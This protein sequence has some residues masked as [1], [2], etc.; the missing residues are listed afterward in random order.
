MT[1]TETDTHTIRAHVPV[2]VARKLVP[3]PGVVAPLEVG[4]PRSLSAV[5]AATNTGD[6]GDKRIL[7]VPQRDPDQG[8]P[9]PEDLY[10]VGVLAEIVQETK[11]G[12]SHRTVVLRYLERQRVESFEDSGKHL[13]ATV[14]PFASVVPSDHELAEEMIASIKH[15]MIS[16][17]SESAESPEQVKRE[18]LEIEDPDDLVDLAIAHL[19]L[20][21]DEQVQLL[22]ESAVM[23]RLGAVLPALER[24]GE[25]LQ[26]K[27]DIRDEL[28]GEMSGVHREKVLRDRMRSIKEEL[29]EQD[30]DTEIDE[31]LER[32]AECEM[33]DEIRL[34]AKKQVARMRMAG[35]SSPE[36]NVA[37]T[38]LE[39]LLDLPWGVTTEDTI[40]VPAAR[41]ILDHDHAGLDK[42]KKRI[43]EFIAVRKLAPNRKGPILCLVG[44][45]G[46]GKTSL[47][48]S[49]ATALGRNY[50]RVSLGGL[51]DESEIRGHRRTYIGALP[52]RLIGGLKKA[53]S[54]NPVFVLDEID[55]MAS[56]IRG[57]P[58][59]ALLEALDP[60]QNKEFV[61]HYLEVAV[62]LS[63]V[64]FIA[65]ANETETIPP[66]LMDRLEI[67]R[68]PG[69]TEAEK[70]E[71]GRGYIIPKQMREHGLEPEQLLIDDAAIR[72]LVHHYTREAGVR[73]LERELAAVCRQA[74]VKVA[75]S[76]AET[77][78]VGEDDVEE[79]LGPKRFFSE[80]AAQRA[81]VG[82]ST[83]LAWTPTGGDLLFVETR[84]MP[85]KGELKL[86]GQ[87]GDVMSESAQASLSYL[88]ANAARFDI[89]PAHIATSDIHVH[90]PSGA[91]RKDGPS[92]GLA[93]TV[94]LVSLLT[95][96]PVRPDVAITGEMTLRGTVLPVGGIKEKVLAAHRGDA[97]T[98]VL[99]ERNRMDL[100]EIPEE[101]RDELEILFVKRVDEA[102]ELATGLR[103]KAPVI[104]PVMVRPKGQTSGV[105]PTP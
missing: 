16:I 10:D 78:R 34:V 8:A 18:I 69:Y 80:V 56:G 58:A 54:M 24:Y 89:D 28:I 14:A 98:V 90:V 47:G 75:S 55:K 5:E 86:T 74:A 9:D 52:G 83:A 30:E 27:S 59:S 88:R 102:I 60:E 66:A 15:L 51:R 38:Y 50:V 70:L 40:D 64:M 97:K 63:K 21:R 65:T 48:R 35:S 33:P 23:N 4:R 72:M 77:V 101:I 19:D 79:I 57:D 81:Q 95:R 93:M 84:L 32:I 20:S 99:P 11:H 6:G 73:N 71:I 41:A 42:V 85:G 53:G 61:D 12:K 96:R 7:V 104:P 92:A 49:V 46:V 39:W 37:R 87:V 1:M 94:A 26:V 76:E 82:V 103:A 105:R 2:L 3:T 36:Y 67:I 44:P 43:V 100:E 68:I 45:P 62:D 91:I 13:V 17:L 22:V 29:G 25:V 31:Y